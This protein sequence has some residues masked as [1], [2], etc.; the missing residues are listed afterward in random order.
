LLAILRAYSSREDAPSCRIGMEAKWVAEESVRGRLH[1]DTSGL[2]A[3]C[4]GNLWSRA[5]QNTGMMKR[6]I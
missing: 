2:G 6:D 4:S 5:F 1:D 3:Q